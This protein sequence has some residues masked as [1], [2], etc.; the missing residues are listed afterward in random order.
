MKKI[1]FIILLFF[2]ISQIKAQNSEPSAW[3]FKWGF[4]QTPRELEVDS[5]PQ[6]DFLT[7][8][9]WSGSGKMNR[10]LGNNSVAGGNITI[11]SGALYSE[12]LKAIKQPYFDHKT[13]YSTGIRNAAAMVYEPTLKIAKPGE[14]AYREDDPTNAIFGFQNIVGHIIPADSS[15]DENY[16][17][18][19]L[20]KWLAD[21]GDVK[22]LSNI[23]P[24]ADFETFNG[25]SQLYGYRGTKWYLTVNLRR[26]NP[27][28]ETDTSLKLVQNSGYND[29]LILN[30][31]WPGIA[32][33]SA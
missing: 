16:N 5:F 3:N 2:G 10:A 24:N 22:V 33:H 23:W 13:K 15:F 20:H 30:N 9:Q 17:R 31:S 12:P 11:D 14:F 6:N 4:S 18:L 19:I 8:F 29:S 1:A 26:L 27:V 7:G 21:T 32:E 25:S 28:G